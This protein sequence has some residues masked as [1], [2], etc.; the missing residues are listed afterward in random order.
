MGRSPHRTGVREDGSEVAD[1]Q[2]ETSLRR[3]T[4]S[5]QMAVRTASPAAEVLDHLDVSAVAG[6]AV[7]ERGPH[8]LLLK[9]VKRFRYGADLA[10]ALAIAIVLALLI[11][12]AIT[13][14]VL[15]GLPAAFLPA[16]P[17]LLEHRPEMAISAIEDAD[18]GST[19]VT[20]HGQATEELAA[21]LDRYLGGLPPANGSVPPGEVSAG[22]P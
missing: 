3:S 22:A 7:A 2:H 1:I 10:A 19:R 20:A 5:Y 17:L 4:A 12:T 16:V 18:D 6:M 14:L 21:F 8:Y 13:P 9:P 15:A 11:C